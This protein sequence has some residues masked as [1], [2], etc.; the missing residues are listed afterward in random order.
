MNLRIRRVTGI[1]LICYT[2]L[3]IQLNVVQ[4]VR[5]DT[6][7]ENPAN[8]RDI[9]RE[10]TEA[11]GTIRTGDGVVVALTVDVPG[12]L[13][14]L[15]E[16]PHGGLYAHLTG[17]FSLNYGATGLERQYHDVLA[18]TDAEIELQSVTDLFVD[19]DRTADLNLTIDH[20]VQRI[21][22][23]AIGDREGAVVAID[24]QTGAILA[25]YSFPTY[26]P[27]LFSSHDL[28]Q[29]QEDRFT[30][31]EDETDPLV[32]RAYAT[33]T[34]P[35]STFKV[36][37]AAA[38][39][40]AGYASAT[41]P[42]YEPT[43]GY[44]PPQT[45]RP[46]GNFG[47]STCGGDLLEMMRVSCNTGIAEMAV[48]LGAGPLI[49]TAHEFGFNDDP[50]LDLDG[51]VESVTPPIDFFDDNIP[52]LAQSAIGQFEVAATPLQMAQVAAAVANDGVMMRPYLVESIVD[53]DGRTIETT[54]PEVAGTPIEFETALALQEMMELTAASGTATGLAF[55]GVAVAGKTGTA[56]SGDAP[57]DAW[58]IGYAP[59]EQPRVAVAVM[60][61]GEWV[62]QDLT[63]ALHAAPVG[64]AVLQAALEAL[65]VVD[66]DSGS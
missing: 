10:F 54:E 3:F 42:V 35:G 56:E 16:Y 22:R 62:A 50:M 11:R 28:R 14:R 46:I 15:R 32:S 43:D 58:I 64:R 9:V 27:G 2:L 44:V 12:E 24:T 19:R 65:G 52:L 25:M 51:V 21:A 33:R 8:T 66:L 13:E 41:S 7:R 17:W 31:V 1:L 20:D 63:G 6:Y 23:A 55:D 18:G 53:S 4:I 36:V 29:V 34:P 30:L 38:A 48:G 26:D 37:T 40:D 60:L 45:D 5:A 61:S 49:R 39:I 47:G 57:T 59:A